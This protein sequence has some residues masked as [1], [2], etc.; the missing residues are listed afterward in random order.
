M[1]LVGYYQKRECIFTEGAIHP[2]SVHYGTMAYGREEKDCADTGNISLI[3]QIRITQCPF[4]RE[5]SRAIIFLDFMLLRACSM[6]VFESSNIYITKENYAIL[7]VKY[8][9]GNI[10][11]EEV[12]DLTENMTD[13][14]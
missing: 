5:P 12:I 9:E 8:A 1:D 14:M 2:S 3:C 11:Q 4:L 10:F 13:A 6:E 7:A